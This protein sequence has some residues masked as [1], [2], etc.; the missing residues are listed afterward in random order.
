MV[1]SDRLTFSFVIDLLLFGFFQGWL[2]EDDLKLREQG[3]SEVL[4]SI[5]GRQVPFFGLVFYL[6]SRPPLRNE[7][8]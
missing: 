7:E 1:C 4:N 2:I 8:I 6:I 5:I 3:E